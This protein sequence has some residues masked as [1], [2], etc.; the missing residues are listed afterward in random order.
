M[1]GRQGQSMAKPHGPADRLTAAY[2]EKEEIEDLPLG[3][4]FMALSTGSNW[5]DRAMKNGTQK[6]EHQH[7]FWA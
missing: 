6:Y 7:H 3:D 2:W 4:F 1:E 5:Q